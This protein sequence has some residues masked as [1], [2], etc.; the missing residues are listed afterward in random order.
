MR[1]TTRLAQTGVLIVGVLAVLS[2]GIARGQTP[3]QA[4]RTDAQGGITVKA[5][6]VTSA[7][8]KASPSDPLSGKVDLERN[9][10]FAITLDAHSG[11]L[12]KYDFIKNIVLRNDRGQEVTPVRWV[13]TADG[14]H[15][16][17]GGLLFPKA[18]QTSQTIDAQAKTL[19]LTVRNL[20]GVAERTLRW[21][22]PVQ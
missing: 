20:G 3:A 5:V 8:F 17:A 11:D 18:D 12:S 14:T 13:A 22:L 1:L 10:V 9:V 2:A 16:R 21:T 4:T 6:Y 19:E 15:H 7:Y